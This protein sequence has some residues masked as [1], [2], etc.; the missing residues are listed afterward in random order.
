[1]IF[2]EQL[3]QFVSD[4]SGSAGDQRGGRGRGQGVPQRSAILNTLQAAKRLLLY[5]P[6]RRGSD[7]EK[8]ARRE[9]HAF[10]LCL[11]NYAPTIAVSTP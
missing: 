5:V 6:E 9:G 3:G 8:K 2:G 1:M 4:S 10:V 11:K 7:S